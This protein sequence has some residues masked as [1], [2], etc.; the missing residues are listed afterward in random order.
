M[1]STLVVNLFSF[2]V[3]YLSGSS[4]LTT[5][6]RP[7]DQ[8]SLK[9]ADVLIMTALNHTPMFNPDS[10]LG[11]FCVAVGMFGTEYSI[12]YLVRIVMHFA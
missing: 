6:P 5:H 4:T 7:I 11:E 1:F 10:M 8:S 3:A 12:L 2:Q 9:N